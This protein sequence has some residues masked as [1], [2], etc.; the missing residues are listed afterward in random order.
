[1]L[2]LLPITPVWV[3]LGAKFGQKFICRADIGALLSAE[4]PSSTPDNAPK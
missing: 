4:M 3:L 1:V 2:V